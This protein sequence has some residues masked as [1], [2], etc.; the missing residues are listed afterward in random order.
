V[1]PSLISSSVRS[2]A[3]L[4]EL[5]NKALSHRRT[6]ATLR[7][8]NSSR[9]HAM[10]TITIKNTLLPYADDGQLILVE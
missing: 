10:L 1:C 9:S 4:E 8:A 6:T 3:E 2:S 7:N 5:I